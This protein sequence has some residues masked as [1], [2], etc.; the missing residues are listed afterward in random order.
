MNSGMSGGLYGIWGS[1]G[2]D[3]FAVGD[4]GTILHYGELARC[5]TLADVVERYDAYM[6]GQVV[7]DD[8]I[9]CYNQYASLY[10]CTI[11]WYGYNYEYGYPESGS[12]QTSETSMTEEAALEARSAIFGGCDS[13][14]ETDLGCNEYS[15]T[16]VYSHYVYSESS[17]TYFNGLYGQNSLEITYSGPVVTTLR[18]GTWIVNCHLE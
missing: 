2:T 1:S 3:V 18:Q 4:Y 17:F 5:S 7:W 8:V 9:S 15:C 10:V 14:Y 16:C 12:V 13:P 11:D 6:S